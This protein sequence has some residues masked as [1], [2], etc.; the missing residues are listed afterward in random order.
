MN[1][2]LHELTDVNKYVAFT[3]INRIRLLVDELLGGVGEYIKE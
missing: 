2:S 3:F 1:F